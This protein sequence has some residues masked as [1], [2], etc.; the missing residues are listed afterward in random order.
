[1]VARVADQAAV[2]GEGQVPPACWSVGRL[3]QL[4]QEVPDDA[5]VEVFVPS[6]DDDGMVHGGQWVVNAFSMR[7][8]DEQGDDLGVQLALECE[9]R[10]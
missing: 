9:I 4:L 1:M 10:R 6:E 2:H 5:L 8:L 7:V 3:R